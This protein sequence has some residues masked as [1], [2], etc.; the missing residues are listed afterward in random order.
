MPAVFVHGVPETPEIW[1]PLIAELQR[2]DVVA[3]QLPGFGIDLPAGFEPTMYRYSEWLAAELGSLT[4]VDL[5]THDWG[6]LL[7]VRVLAAR[8]PGVR[9]WVVDSGNLDDGFEWHDT[10]KIWQTPEA[11][12]AFVE[13]FVNASEPE[14]AAALEAA[15]APEAGAAIMAAHLDPLMGKSI[16]ALYRS[17]TGIGSEWGPGI[18]SIDGPGL[19]VDAGLDGFRA[20]GAARRLGERTGARV[21][22]L[23]DSGH[24]WMC[25]DPAGASAFLEGFWAELA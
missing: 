15:G 3:L 16:L 18:D 6:A 9:S 11:G 13:G 4:D 17:A 12:E 24:W 10:A 19:V 25:E 8:P 2:D 7:A 1:D 23:P 14:R 21:V 5:V 20:R 22:D